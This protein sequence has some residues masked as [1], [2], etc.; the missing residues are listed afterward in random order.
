MIELRDI[1]G[2]TCPLVI[3]D[4][5]GDPITET[6]IVTITD[7][8]ETPR[9]YHKEGVKPGCDPDD[10]G[11]WQELDVFLFQLGHNARVDLKAAERTHR[12]LE[13]IA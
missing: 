8:G 13:M 12:L 2:R 1:G 5:C 6:G 9:F 3:C 7:A 4:T 10:F 11:S